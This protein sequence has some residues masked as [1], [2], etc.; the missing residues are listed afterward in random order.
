ME[1]SEYERMY[2]YEQQ[3][4]WFV[5]TRN[6]ILGLLTKYLVNK[7][8]NGPRIID[9]GC[10]T[11]YTMLLMQRFGKVFGIDVASEGLRLCMKRGL[12]NICQADLL[13]IPCKRNSFDVALALDVLEHVE[14]DHAAVREISGILHP[15]GKLLVTVPA[16]RFLW[17]HHDNALHHKRRYTLAE[18][19]RLLENNDFKIERITYYNSFL[20]PLISLVRIGRRLLRSKD[21][22]VS[23]LFEVPALINS[24]LIR[25]FDVEGR[26][27]SRVNLPIGVS[28]LCIASKASY[29]RSH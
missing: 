12:V 27:L 28:L 26:I 22:P 11:G 8:P 24:F 21:D 5:G 7:T 20:F 18:L 17:S 19:K 25:L 3:H 9:L 15:E 1:T 16:F 10:G 14:D 2:A 13:S 23:D 29:Q 4:W 6:V